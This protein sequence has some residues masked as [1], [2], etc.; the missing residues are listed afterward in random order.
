MDSVELEKMFWNHFKCTITVRAGFMLVGAR[1]F[2]IV[3]WLEYINSAIYI[4]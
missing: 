3:Q 4:N 1:N 2:V